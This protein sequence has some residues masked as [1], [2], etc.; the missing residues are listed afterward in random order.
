MRGLL[1]LV[2]RALYHVVRQMEGEHFIIDSTREV[3]AFFRKVIGQFHD[4]KLRAKVM[5][6]E[7]CYPNMPKEVIRFAMRAIL[8]EARRN[9]KEGVSVP[10]RSKSKPCTW[11]RC[12]GSYVWIGFETMLE[13][14]DF[15]LDQAIMRMKDGRLV[16]QVR[17]IPMGDAL[18]PAM[19]IGTCAWM[20]REW[21]ATLVGR[22]HE[23][24]L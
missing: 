2:G 14:L 19:T 18:S 15:S 24:S 23:G 5:D 1:G 21:M 11:K 7:G 6:I 8:Q 9:G 16:R 20:E 17:G 3:P 10:K 22:C 12:G 4:A 13:V